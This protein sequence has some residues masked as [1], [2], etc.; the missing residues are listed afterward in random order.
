MN[1]T[2]KPTW[3]NR[4]E[5][6]LNDLQQRRKAF[7]DEHKPAV[8]KAIVATY[9]GLDNQPV[10]LEGIVNVWIGHAD[11]IRDALEPFDS[12]VRAGSPSTS[13]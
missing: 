8:R 12:G 4:D 3:S 10:R 7:I 1:T 5:A 2:F 13:G 11:A 9:E 6:A